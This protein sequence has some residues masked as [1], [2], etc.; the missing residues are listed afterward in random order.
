[1]TPRP[2]ASQEASRAR[3]RGVSA[4]VASSAISSIGDGASVA[5]LPLLAAYLTRDPLAVA[6]VSGSAAAPWVLVGV[7]SGAVVDRFPRRAVM[8]LADIVRAFGLAVL[9]ALVFFDSASIAILAAAAFLVTAGKAFF[10]AAAQAIIPQLVGKAGD[11]LSA[12]NGRMAAT[13]TAGRSLAGPPLGGLAFS[14][15]PWLPFAV[16]AL[17]FSASAL[18]LTRVPSRP[19]PDST[20]QNLI[21]ATNEGF[22]YLFSDRGLLSLAAI[23]G[24]YNFAYNMAFGVFVLYA[25]DILSLGGFGFGLLLAVSS[26]GAIVAGWRAR[27]IVSRL[28]IRGGIFVSV[29][30]QALGWFLIVLTGSIVAAGA[31]LALLGAA[32]TLITVTI[33]T[34]R[35]QQVPDH[36][37]GRVVSAFRLFGNGAA[38]AGAAVGGLLASAYSLD[39]PLWIAALV[40]LASALGVLGVNLR[41]L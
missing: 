35:Q 32:S 29:A 31:A 17:S 39:A 4:L 40:A 38:P 14:W 28:G 22:R 27:W 34:A 20:K 7:W 37:L 18:I 15:S 41:R 25:Q 26:L 23:S 19:K 8:V 24:L 12:V 36:L 2:N 5:A 21:S 9:A 1:M 30:A 11:D 3:P 13:E 10:D 33:I 6:V 16:D